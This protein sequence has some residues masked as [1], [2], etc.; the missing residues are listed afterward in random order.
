MESALQSNGIQP[1]D[2]VAHLIDST[3]MCGQEK[4]SL[5]ELFIFAKYFFFKCSKKST[6]R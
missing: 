6:N 4:S 5:L 1:P 2:L 3:N